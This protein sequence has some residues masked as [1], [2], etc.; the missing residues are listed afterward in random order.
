MRDARQAG[1]ILLP[2]DS[3]HNAI[4]QAMGGHRADDVEAMILTASGGPFRTWANERI[5]DG[6]PRRGAGPSQ[7]VDGREDHDRLGA[8]MNK[9]LELIEA[10]H[11]FGVPPERLEFW[12][13]PSRSC[14]A[15]SAS[16][17]GSVVAGLAWPDMQSADRPLPRVPGPAAETSARRLD[18]AAIARL[19]FEAPDLDR[20][21]AL[22]SGHARH[23]KRRGDADSAECRERDR[24]RSL[25]VRPVVVS[26]NST[27]VESVMEGLSRRDSDVGSGRQWRMHSRWTERLGMCRGTILAIRREIGSLM[28][29]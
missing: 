27:L 13:I 1:S 15:W 16:R 25:P 5:A 17:D 8:L 9:G 14:T 11:L 21:P 6:R 29:Y 19:D 3:E 10:H 28:V 26:R 23:A 18:L 4:F 12:F 22:E 2:L 24:G 20:F 7:L